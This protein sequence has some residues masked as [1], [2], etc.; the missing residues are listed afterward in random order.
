[1]KSPSKPSSPTSSPPSSIP[2]SPSLPSSTSP[3]FPPTFPSSIS[4]S[5]QAGNILPIKPLKIIKLQ[6]S[7]NSN[8]NSNSP[9]SVIIMSHPLDSTVTPHNNTHNNTNDAPYSSPIN[10]LNT[11]PNNT[12][13]NIPNNNISNN[14]PFNAPNNG[15]NN[16]PYNVPY[17]PPRPSYTTHTPPPL[18]LQSP[19]SS[20]STIEAEEWIDVGADKSEYTTVT[21]IAL[22]SPVRGSPVHASG[23]NGSPVNT[24]GSPVH[25]F[26]RG[27]YSGNVNG[28]YNG[29][30]SYSGISNNNSNGKVYDLNGNPVP[31][32][33]SPPVPAPV[34]VTYPSSAYP[35]S[36][37]H[38]SSLKKLSL[39]DTHT[40]ITDNDTDTT[41]VKATA[42]HTPT[43][44][45]V[46][47]ANGT[48]KHTSTV[49]GP[50]VGM[51]IDTDI[52]TATD[53]D[54]SMPVSPLTVRSSNANTVTATATAIGYKQV[55]SNNQVNHP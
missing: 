22:D 24:R 28:N 17:A 35:S 26:G 7:S 6:N 2:P 37:D 46:G 41:T 25:S 15:Q 33:S 21:A 27:S 34:T 9:T 51:S 4:S 31:G 8:S 39:A 49:K 42:T 29:V 30:G 48:A 47:T 53:I 36:L 40:P 12:S 16:A 10:T 20:F 32:F 18:T 19:S 44:Y 13:N 52:I 14:T 45:N 1:M 3:T 54:Y 11:V 50:P 43:Q 55:S 23:S 5:L 38:L